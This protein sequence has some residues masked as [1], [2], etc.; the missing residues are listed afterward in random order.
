MHSCTEGESSARGSGA[1]EDELVVSGEVAGEEAFERRPVEVQGEG[2][3]RL[4]VEELAC[5]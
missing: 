3:V 5:W 1:C 4:P 2:G